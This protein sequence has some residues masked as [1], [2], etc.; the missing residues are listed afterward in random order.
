MKNNKLDFSKLNK[1]FNIEGSLENVILEEFDYNEIVSY[2]KE[3]N[4]FY[5][6]TH[7]KETKSFL[8]KTTLD[9]CKD[10]KFRMSRRNFGEKNGMY[11]SARFGDLNPM[12]GKTHSEETKLKQS[13]KKKEWFKNNESPLKGKPCPEHVKKNLSEKNSKEY[14]LISPEGNEIKVKNLTK[15]ARDNNLSINC[16]NHVVS[17]RNKSHKGWKNAS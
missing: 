2:K 14:T 15:F 16:L 9:L 17:G 1:T 7:T 8:R 11:K 13:N 4:P 5:G 3:I 12:W 10:E 6:K